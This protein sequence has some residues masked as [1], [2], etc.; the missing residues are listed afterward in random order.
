MTDAKG[1]KAL[2]KKLGILRKA[3]NAKVTY[4]VSAIKLEDYLNK[5]PEQVDLFDELI[6]HPVEKEP[7]R[8]QATNTYLV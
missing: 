5:N 1:A 7:L 6:E 4:T 3:S 2:A 8:I